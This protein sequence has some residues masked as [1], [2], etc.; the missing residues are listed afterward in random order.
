VNWTYQGNPVTG[1]EIER[2]SLHKKRDTWVGTTLVGSAGAND[3]SYVDLSGNGTFHYRVRSV[4]VLG[5][6]DWS[7][8]SGQVLVT[9][10]SGGGKGG[11]GGN[12][13]CKKNKTC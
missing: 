7:A 6:S 1:F 4:N 13:N 2:Q 3:R 5:A 9:G 11:G 12:G 8:W 10:A